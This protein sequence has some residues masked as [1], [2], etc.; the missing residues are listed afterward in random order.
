VK[1]EMV[2]NYSRRIILAVL[3][4]SIYALFI[5][6]P[7]FSNTYATF[8]SKLSKC[9]ISNVVNPTSEEFD[10]KIKKLN[11]LLSGFDVGSK[12]EVLSEWTY[13]EESDEVDVY[14]WIEKWTIHCVVGR[15]YKFFIGPLE[16]VYMAVELYSG[17]SPLDGYILQE[18]NDELGG[19]IEFTWVCMETGDYDFYIFEDTRNDWENTFKPTFVYL[20][21]EEEPEYEAEYWG[22]FCG[23]EDYPGT[24]SDLKYCNDDAKEFSEVLQEYANWD[25]E[26][27]L[28]IEDAESDTIK[29]GIMI[30]DSRD[31]AEDT[32]LF[33]YSGHGGY[34]HLWPCDTEE[35]YD[36]E[37]KSWLD[38]CDS[39]GKILILDCCR[40]GT[41]LYEFYA[42]GYFTIVSCREDES[43]Y[44]SSKLEHSVFTYFV[45]EG[46]KRPEM[47]ADANGDKFISGEEIFDYVAPRT[48]DFEDGKQ[49]PAMADRINGVLIAITKDT[50][51]DGLLDWDESNIYGTDPENSDTDGDRL[52]DGEEV[53]IGTDYLNP[54]TDGDGLLDGDEVLTYHSSPFDTDTDDDEVGDYDEAVTYGT[55]PTKPDTDG[56]GLTDY[57][58]IFTFKTDPLKVDTDG[59][60]LSDKDELTIYKTD[61][62]SIDTDND[63]LNDGNEVMIGTNPLDNDSDD[64]DFLDGEEIETGTDPLNSDTDGDGLLDGDEVKIRKTNPLKVDTDGD[65]WKDSTDWAPTN[66]ILPNGLFI[67]IAIIGITAVV[68]FLK[69]RAAAPVQYKPKI[70]AGVKICPYCG[71]ENLP[72]AVFCEKCGRRIG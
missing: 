33:F 72:D 35:V 46:L 30:V 12:S 34:Y 56:D 19:S 54:D 41:F 2:V 3:I 60:G 47:Q 69:R 29:A 40:S 50:D 67:G 17:G 8:E 61:P 70:V 11:A 6:A 16:D 5:L 42:P 4:I 39:Q 51:G 26:H 24:E 37:L 14:I 18:S 28:V 27:I 66:P 23:C 21:V 38:D 36:D 58:E 31:G 22:I 48:S 10:K 63:N 64:D 71:A 59:D 53:N 62:L 9:S 49:N 52:S 20:Y 55:D 44:E 1:R 68:F 57:E 7:L 45:I 65:F 13:L 15:E 25:E 32:L 43:S